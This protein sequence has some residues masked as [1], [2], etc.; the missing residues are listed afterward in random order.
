MVNIQAGNSYTN[1]Q[2]AYWNEI[3]TLN[4]HHSMEDYYVD[5]ISQRAVIDFFSLF[6]HVC[7]V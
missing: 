7:Q 4:L 3:F 2:V 6:G 1:Y 5:C